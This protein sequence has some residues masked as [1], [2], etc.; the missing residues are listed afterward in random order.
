MRIDV[1]PR[2]LE[3][4]TAILGRLVPE[5]EVRAFG[6]RVRGKARKT[7]DLDLAIMTDLPLSIERTAEL[8]DAFRESDLPFRVEFL[9]WAVTDERFRKIVESESV[10]LK[11]RRVS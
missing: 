6:S 1:E 5:Y 3:A 9:D 11:P 10:S 7:S 4:V 8:R 2:D